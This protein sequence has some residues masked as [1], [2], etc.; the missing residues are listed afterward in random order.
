MIKLEEKQNG[1]NV[2]SDLVK[3]GVIEYKDFWDGMPYISL[4]KID[5]GYR[6][7][8]IGAKAM[9][10]FEEEMRGKGEKAILV[11]TQV[12]EQAQNFYRKIG[13]TE[14]GC[15]ILENTPFKQPMEMFFIKTL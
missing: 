11:S 9:Q 10:L 15:L 3:V 7:K 8:G 12:D 5:D 4:I 14:C 1:Y 6:R 2:L 13:Y